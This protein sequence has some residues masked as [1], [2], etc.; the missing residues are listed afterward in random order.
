MLAAR[1]RVAVLAAALAGSLL[2]GMAE[3]DRELVFFLFI[4][5][6]AGHLSPLA[7]RWAGVLAPRVTAG[8]AL[9]FLACYARFA[10]WAGAA[11]PLG[12]DAAWGIVALT[13]AV[14]AFLLFAAIDG[15]HARLRQD[16]LLGA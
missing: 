8:A 1:T 11:I 6:A 9:G 13:L 7:K 15:L 16:G 12:L 14:K 3:P 4:G 2:T 10:P 5:A